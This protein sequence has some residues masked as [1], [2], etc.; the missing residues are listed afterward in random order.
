MFRFI[1]KKIAPQ[2]SEQDKKTVRSIK[3]KKTMR[4]VN[5]AVYVGAEDVKKNMQELHRKTRKL[6]AS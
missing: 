2:V 4:A 6:V 5:G 1:F 3:S